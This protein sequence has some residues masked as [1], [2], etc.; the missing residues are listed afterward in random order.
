MFGFGLIHGLGFAGVL[1]EI[2]LNTTYFVPALIA[3]NIGVEIGQ[4]VILL[5]CFLLVGLW[6]RKKSWYRK[7]IT[8]PASLL[9]AI[10]G[11]FWLIDRLPV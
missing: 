9:I 7:L 2:G 8:I 1:S 11:V 3:F 4:L 10:A 5:G 6:F